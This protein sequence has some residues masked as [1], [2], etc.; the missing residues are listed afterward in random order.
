MLGKISLQK[1]LIEI[2][3]AHRDLN[4]SQKKEYKISLTQSDFLK[5]QNSKNKRITKINKIPISY[6]IVFH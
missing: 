6:M 3:E 2:S 4:H 1:K 5:D